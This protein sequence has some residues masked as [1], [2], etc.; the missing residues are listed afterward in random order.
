[1]E[2]KDS[3]CCQSKSGDGQKCASKLTCS[4]CLIVAAVILAIVVLQYFVR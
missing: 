4:P 1:M 2:N 3:C